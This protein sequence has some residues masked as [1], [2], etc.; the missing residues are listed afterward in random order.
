[1]RISESGFDDQTAATLLAARQTICDRLVGEFPRLKEDSSLTERVE[2]ALV[3][4]ARAGQR[5][6]EVLARYATYASRHAGG[7]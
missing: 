5:D 3:A 7:F 6:L 2:G 4:L 1:M